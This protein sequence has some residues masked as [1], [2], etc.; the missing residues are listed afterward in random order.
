MSTTSS[1]PEQIEQE[2][3]EEQIRIKKLHYDLSILVRLQMKNDILHIKYLNVYI[4]DSMKIIVKI[5]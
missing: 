1:S 5:V 3:L 2:T 4:I